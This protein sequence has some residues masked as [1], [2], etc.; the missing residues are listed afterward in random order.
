MAPAVQAVAPAARAAAA[1][2][3]QGAIAEPPSEPRVVPAVAATAADVAKERLPTAEP[4]TAAEASHAEPN[5]VEAR[6]NAPSPAPERARPAL[7]G[8]TPELGPHS[9]V[10]SHV[11]PETGLETATFRPRRVWHLLLAAAAVLAVAGTW[12]GLRSHGAQPRIVAATSSVAPHAPARA[13]TAPAPPIPPPPPS[14]VDSSAAAVPAPTASSGLAASFASAMSGKTDAVSVT[15]HLSPAGASLFRHGERLGADEVTVDVPRGTKV[16]LVAQLDGY[17]PR[18]V[19]LDSSSKHVNVVLARP[20]V[21]AARAAAPADDAP[22]STAAFNPS[23]TTPPANSA[24]SPTPAAS[25]STAPSSTTKPAAPAATG[26]S[27]H[28]DPSDDLSP[29]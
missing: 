16:T 17:L 22:T 26:S 6:D 12:L 18:A 5:V 28:W 24:T 7:D 15:V 8:T 27:R 25:P 23:D 1:S 4:A 2:P 19:V 20:S 9:L 21:K 10:P 11:D 3:A 13:T 14:V 29:L